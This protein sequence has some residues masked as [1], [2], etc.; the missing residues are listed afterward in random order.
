MTPE[1]EVVTDARLLAAIHA[2]CFA[3]PWSELFFGALLV[4]PGVFALAAPAPTPEGFILMRV[5][6]DEAEILT[7]AV[8]PAA[9]RR[10][11]A[12]AL[13]AAALAAVRARRARRCFLEVAEDNAAA[14]ALYAHAGFAAVARRPQY[15]RRADGGGDAV[16][17]E[18]A[19]RT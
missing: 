12:R 4:Q 2:E 13:L 14:R 8:C 1:C 19:W 3:E 11:L 17:M 15:Y 6:A 18:L 5:A 10:G 9:R 16:T 7:L